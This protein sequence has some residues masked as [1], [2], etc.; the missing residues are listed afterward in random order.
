MGDVNG[1]VGVA[2]ADAGMIA[3]ASPMIS[4]EARAEKK[5]MLLQTHVKSESQP[6]SFA[7]LTLQA[8]VAGVPS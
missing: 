3:T 6:T 7:S 5:R 2:A 8:I 4:V 1:I